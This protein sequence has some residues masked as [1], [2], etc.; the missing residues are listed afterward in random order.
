MWG[1]G[2]VPTGGHV[3]GQDGVVPIVPNRNSA[4][5][6]MQHQLTRQRKMITKTLQIYAFI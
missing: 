1:R 3:D 2:D 4:N 5:F 6:P